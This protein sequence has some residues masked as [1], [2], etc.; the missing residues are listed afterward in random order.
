LP[1]SFT[2]QG[3]WVELAQPTRPA[4]DPSALYASYSNFRHFGIQHLSI[5]DIPS[6]FL[7]NIQVPV[8]SLILSFRCRFSSLSMPSVHWVLAVQC[9]SK[10]KPEIIRYSPI[11]SLSLQSVNQT[12]RSSCLPR[13]P[14][15]IFP[16]S[17]N[18]ML[19]TKDHKVWCTRPSTRDT[20]P[21]R[22]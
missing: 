8:Q 4:K 5:L 9:S 14:T 19:P 17:L 22:A 3:A 16:R 21:C 1:C 7:S 18:P 15:S 6:I 13:V 10:L 11:I 2:D 12:I 20:I